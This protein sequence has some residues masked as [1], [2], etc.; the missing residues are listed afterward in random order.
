MRTS[1][2][3]LL[4]CILP[5]DNPQR[6]L[7]PVRHSGSTVQS[8][9]SAA[10]ADELAAFANSSGGVLLLGVGEPPQGVVGI[11]YPLL[12]AVER[13]VL[14]ALDDLIQPPIDLLIERATLPDAQG[15]SRPVMRVEAP[16]SLF[17][18]QSP[19]GYLHR[20]GSSKRPMSPEVLARLFQQRSQTRLIRFDEQPIAT[21]TLADLDYR[22]WQRFATERTQ[23]TP[24]DLLQKLGM[25]RMDTDGALR[26]TVAGVL[27]ACR[28]PRRF[29]PNAYIQAV[30]YRGTSIDPAVGSAYQLDAADL[31][32]PLDEQIAGACAF[33]GRN[34]RTMAWKDAGRID[35]PQFHRTAVFEA[36]VN[37]VAHRDYSIYGSKIRL[38]LFAD[39]L[40]IYSP[41]AIPNTMTVES[42]AYRQSARNEVLTSLLAKCPNS[43]PL[44]GEPGERRWIMEK[45]G[46][47][48]PLILSRSRALSGKEP[49]YRLIDDAE[50]LLVIY[51]ASDTGNARDS[52]EESRDAVDETESP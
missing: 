40:E 32:G 26:P 24:E 3:E 50:L 33:V 29:I 6:L 17:V 35:V 52:E 1:R 15:V 37:A 49:T 13:Q 42:L 46:E 28:D 7:M 38:R 47:G 30:A 8:P 22:L 9:T 4:A 43:T 18:H 2:A 21:A 44:G 39:R 19:G 20:V 11:P 16:R 41:G 10:L 51:A 45:R 25:A 23:D 5:D 48:V 27:M 36:V 14:K 34:M 31:V 12:D